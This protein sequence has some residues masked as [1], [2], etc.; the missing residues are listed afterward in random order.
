MNLATIIEEHPAEACALI[1]RGKPTDY[2]TLRDQVARLRT[3]LVDLGLQPGDRLA[4]VSGNNRYFVVSYL[5]ALG[6]GLVVVPLNP[7]NPGVAV[8]RE[9]NTVA[10]RAVIVGPAGRAA[11]EG[12]D[13]S[14]IPAVE[15]VIGAGFTPSGGLSLE[16]LQATV[17]EASEAAPIVQREPVRHG[18]DDLHLRHRR[19]AT[20]G[21]ADPRQ[22]V[23]QHRA[24]A[25]RRRRR[26]TARRRRVRGVAAVPHLRAERGARS[27]AVRRL[28]GAPGRTVRSGLGPGVDREVGGHDRVGPSDH[29]GGLGR[30]SGGGRIGHRVGPSG[31]VG[32]RQAPRRGRPGDR[33]Q[34]RVAPRGGLRPHRGIPGRHE[35]AGHRRAARIHRHPRAGHGAAHRRQRRGRRARG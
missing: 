23:R 34:V 17:D 35:P 1:S 11:V 2:G 24:A 31:G 32:R 10:A 21:H 4:I 30:G 3:G 12:V 19:L 5:A 6:A 22:P 33:G 25:V 26:T 28:L 13:R 18:G 29:V 7:T 16:E 14:D 9:L 8:A 27:I 20:C 15:F